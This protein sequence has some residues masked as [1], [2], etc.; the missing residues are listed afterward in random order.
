MKQMEQMI[1]DLPTRLFHWLLTACILGA[2]GF[3]QL[4]HEGDSLF[5]GHM[6]LAMLAGVLLVWRF[7]GAFVS[8]NPYF[9]LS[10]L[11]INLK[12][13]INYFLSVFKGQGTYYVG[14][15]PGSI[16]AIWAMFILILLSLITGSQIGSQ[17]HTVKEVHEVVTNLLIL[18]VVFH[19]VGVILASIMHK[20]KYIL[21]MINGMK[22]A[23]PNESVNSNLIGAIILLGVFLGGGAY[24]AS[25][26]D[27]AQQ[28][29]TF[30][31]LGISFSLGENEADEHEEDAEEHEM[32]QKSHDNDEGED[33]KD[34]GSQRGQPRGDNPAGSQGNGNSSD[35]SSYQDQVK[36]RDQ[37][38][39]NELRQRYEEGIK[40][41]QNQNAQSSTSQLRPED[42]NGLPVEEGDFPGDE[43]DDD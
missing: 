43:G 40:K 20:Q 17:G 18:T 28:K 12:E 30:K 11:K 35:N 7:V 22:K 3:A 32:H 41:E 27:I 23:Q 21:S 29:M 14:H 4:F 1:W 25:G 38:A 42:I 8:K 2:Y 26:F 5:Y 36:E 39:L 13:T 9:R 31:G 19:I 24:L 16:L 6:F 15:N 33:E 10:A 34:E 37:Q